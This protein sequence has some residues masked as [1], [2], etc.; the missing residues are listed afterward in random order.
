MAEQNKPVSK[1]E[2]VGLMT[3]LAKR[4]RP[5]YRELRELGWNEAIPRTISKSESPN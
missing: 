2:F 5:R 3:L 1:A 4:D